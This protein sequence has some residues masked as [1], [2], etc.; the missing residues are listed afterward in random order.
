MAFYRKHSVKIIWYHWCVVVSKTTG[1]YQDV[2]I[3][4]VNVNY[5]TSLKK[6]KK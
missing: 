2:E 1:I 5:T 4:W 3:I 6:S